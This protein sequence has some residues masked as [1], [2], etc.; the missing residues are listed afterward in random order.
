MSRR[1]DKASQAAAGA[2]FAATLA[3]LSVLLKTTAHRRP[4]FAIRLRERDLVAQ[5]RLR[6]G[7]QGRW[8]AFAAG[9]VTSGAGLSEHP[10]LTMWFETP[11][12]AARI[13]TP[14]RDYL[15]Y[16]DALKNFQMGVEGPDEL[17][18][19]FSE[20]LQLLFTA[21]VEYGTDMG[22]GV[23]R[24][25]NNTNG[26]PVFV[27]VKGGRIV[28]ITPIE[29]NDD[30]APPWTISAR[31]RRFTPPRKTTLSSH[32]L[33]WKSMVYSPDRILHPLKRIDFDPD[34]DRS[35]QNRGSSG[36][37]RISWNEALDLVAAEIKRVKR[38]HGPGAIVNG[39]GAHHSWG[40]LGHW[41]SA[42]QRFFNTVG[43]TSI[44]MNPDSWEGWY[45]GAV[46]HWGHS[47]RAGAAETY[48]T[49]E[50]CLRYCELVVFWS[51]D[52]EAT[53]GIYAAGEGTVRR[54]WLQSLGVPFV[55]IDPYFN[56]T[57]GLFGGKWLAPRPGSDSALVLAI[58]HVWMSEGLYDKE[59]V[60][61]RTTGFDVWRRYVLGEDDG[62]AKTPEWQER[63]TGVPARD[64]RALARLWGS[65]RTYLAAGGMSG[66]GGAC[67][68]AT[69]TDWARGMVCL[70]AM[71]GLGKPGVNMGCMQQGTPLDTRFFF[72]GY[73]E[74]GFSGDFGAT[75]LGVNMYQRMP[76]LPT[77]N[78]VAQQ[79]PR[80]RLP[81]AVL[82]GS[83][84]G[85]ACD[86]SSIEGQFAGI[87]YPAPGYSR[88]RLYYKYGGS[89][90]GTVSDSNRFARMYRSDQL[91]FV[92]NQSIWM[93]GEAEFADVILPACTNFERW[94]IGEFAGSAGFVPHG[95]TQCNHR[96]IV[97]Q[98]PCVDP[99]GESRSDFQIFLGL[100]QRLGLGAMYSEGMTELDWCRRLFDATD[101]ARRIPW[102][103]FLKKGYYVVP[104]VPE[105]R[106]DPVAYRWYAEGRL[107]D[108]PDVSPLPGDYTE[109]YR[110]GLQT[111]SGKIEFEAS[112]LKR[113]DPDD[114]ER[115]PI[116]KYVP[117]W[118]G[119]H[120]SELYR[121]YP[122][123][124]V[125]AHV[126]H[127]FHTQSDGKSSAINEV[128]G[129]RVL[130]DGYYYWIA[131]INPIDA[132]ARGIGHLSLVELHNDRGAVICAAEL[133]QRVRP[134]VVH[135]YHG[136]AVY[137]PIGEPGASP[138]RG[139]CVNVLTPSRMMIRRSH[140]LAANS[141]LVDVRPWTPSMAHD[142]G[143]PSAPHMA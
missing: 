23:T 125:S 27:Y 9:K 114:P 75:A 84:E 10:D 130:I 91:E 82:E 72:P 138:D 1:R 71:Q 76:Q 57:A 86:P 11:E 53:S 120:A 132:D 7:S 109:E 81:E 93:E 49:V 73:A 116:L 113:F 18:V 62:M 105:E 131:R 89:H 24:Y 29:F 133:T 92:V 136:S 143:S 3:G 25:T 70:M 101:V 52:P 59:Y 66:L 96:V 67:R 97:L 46:H 80:L 16:I 119:P 83:A 126:R 34:G 26:G 63:E 129:H 99:V 90:F 111:Q 88:V 107:K 68:T 110:R 61:E 20:T 60:A 50:D 21:G 14:W 13:M 43:S 32:S 42:R 74:G 35:P 78:T 54:Q 104:P 137:D 98:H 36:Y 55:H 112:S 17:A 115:S 44:A 77:M 6:G 12:V 33:A 128:G 134:G 94:D 28:R 51:S 108:T 118:E 102:R 121:R 85:F 38:D 141:C 30:D 122:L 87:S 127:S 100:A 31:G 37:E 65:R 142:R 22:G 47:A 64:V 58:A 140:S 40:N 39:S 41:L 135:A 5:I 56:H 45:W 123:Q 117:S 69:G 106:R 2:R 124:L 15:E 4:A 48:S 103:Q 19:W 8:Y 95:F 79:V 139:G